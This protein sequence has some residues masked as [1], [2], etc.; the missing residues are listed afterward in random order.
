MRYLLKRV[1]QLL[2]LKI[3]YVSWVSC[4]CF[5]ALIKST[6]LRTDGRIDDRSFWISYV[7]PLSTPLAIPLVYPRMITIHDL[8]S[9]VSNY[10]ICFWCILVFICSLVNFYLCLGWQEMDG[11]LIPPAIPLSSEHVSDDGI[12]L[13]ESGEDCLIYIGN[14]ANPDIMQQLLGI[15]SVNEIPTQVSM[16]CV[17]LF[18]LSLLLLFFCVTWNIM[19][20]IQIA[21]QI[22]TFCWALGSWFVDRF[23]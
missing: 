22:C 20:K 21:K 16:C 12:Y 10:S 2:F 19:S 8:D 15:S 14:S 1:C 7:Y 6:G 5:S 11:S 9:K 4:F 23:C 18:L 13:L 17:L 3:L